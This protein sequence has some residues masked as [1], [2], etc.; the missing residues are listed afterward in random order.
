MSKTPS[1]EAQLKTLKRELKDA[2][3]AKERVRM[4]AEAY[5]SRA[6]KSEQENAEWKR[7]FDAL[8]KIV[9]GERS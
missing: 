9:P 2:I 3:Q 4:E 1:A 8:L 5:R 7:R 6:T